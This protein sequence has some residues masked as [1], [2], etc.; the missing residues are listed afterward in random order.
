MPMRDLT[1]RLRDI[2][3]RD[4][5][6]APVRTLTYV[7]EGIASAS[8]DDA[9]EQLGGEVS[10]I[11]GSACVTIDRVWDATEWHGRRRVSSFVPP[12]D[13]PVALFDP[14]LSAAPAE[15]ASHVLFFDLETTGL[16]GGAGTLPFLAGCGWFEGEDFRVRQFFLAGPG[17]ERAMLDALGDLFERATLLVTFNGRTFDLPLMETR[18]AFH[19]RENPTESLAHFD[20]LPAARRLWRYREPPRRVSA[21]DHDD[22]AEAASCTLASLER[23]VLGFHRVDDVPGLE[24]PA[25]YFHFL[26]TGQV[27][28]VEGVLDHNRYDLLSLAAVMAR[29]LMLGADGAEACADAGEQ[30]GLGRLYERA[31]DAARARCA[32]ELAAQDVTTEAGRFALARWA[33]LLR[34]EGRHDEAAAA[35]QRLLDLPRSRGGVTPLERRAAEALAI[36]H[37]HRARDYETARDY[38]ETVRAHVTGRLADAARHRL[39]RLSRKIGVRRD[40]RE[41]R[42][43]D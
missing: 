4:P 39:S 28:P 15:W 33:E 14:R 30:L 19:R 43:I 13:A 41:P 27:A 29:A 31:G 9:A 37:E 16:S 7:A 2:V 11:E 5:S 38:A 22:D 17:G 18:W 36:H 8:V 12:A 25:R 1:S 42:L 35:W 20:M 24:I 6:P 23:A 26:R 32:F 10:R 34:K 40:A 21:F 3:R